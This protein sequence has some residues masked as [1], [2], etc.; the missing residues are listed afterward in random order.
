MESNQG[1]MTIGKMICDATSESKLRRLAEFNW[2]FTFQATAGD[3]ATLNS[4]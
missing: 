1:K 3:V 4:D 2:V